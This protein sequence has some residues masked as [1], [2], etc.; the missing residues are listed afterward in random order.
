MKKVVIT[1]ATSM[2]GTALIRYFISRDIEILAITRRMTPEL[3]E[4]EKTGKCKIAIC[5]LDGILNFDKD[6]YESDYDAFIHLAWVGTF[7]NERADEELQTQ[8]IKYTLNCV[9]LA[10]DLGCK[11]FLGVGSQAEY[12]RVGGVIRHDTPTNPDTPYGIAKLAAGRMSRHY[13]QRL[14]MKHIWV[15]IFSVYGPHDNPNTMIMSSISNILKGKSM[16]YTEAT[17]T[18]NY[19]YVNDAARGIALACAKGRDGEVY[20]I[21]NKNNYTLKSY[22]TYLRDEINP[23]VEVRFG[24]IP[25]SGGKPINLNVDITRERKE[26]GFVPIYSFDRGIELTIEW[27]KKQ[28]A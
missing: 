8:N 5:N 17:Q 16:S 19:L 7:G 28:N 14:D 18:W 27:Y 11:T 12:G 21:A 15:R 22:I 1:G 26:L 9:D 3:S 13:A 20:C 25:Y 2:I 4:F 6:K 24:E 10:H 23:E